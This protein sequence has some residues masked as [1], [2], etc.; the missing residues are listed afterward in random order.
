MRSWRLHASVGT[1]PS[2]SGLE[3]PVTRAKKKSSRVFYMKLTGPFE[4][5][6]ENKIM[7]STNWR[8]EPLKKKKKWS[9]G[10]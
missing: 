1:G 9:T 10:I 7:S 8:K 6:V 2:L 3:Y 4:V 5:T